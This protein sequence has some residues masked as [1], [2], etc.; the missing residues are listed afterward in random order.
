[1]DTL[2]H[3]KNANA[4][5]VAR[6]FG[7]PPR[8]LQRRLHGLGLRTPQSSINQALMEQEEE[9]IHLYIARLDKLDHYAHEFMIINAA[10]YLLREAHFY[11][12]YAHLYHSIY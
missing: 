12:N 11:N 9:V 6:Q 8:I 7:L 2:E 5:S 3:D 4:A 10:N 1:M